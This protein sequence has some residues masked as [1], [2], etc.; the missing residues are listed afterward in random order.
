MA[1]DALARRRVERERP[2]AAAGE[3]RRRRRWPSFAVLALVVTAL[4]LWLAAR[5]VERDGVRFFHTGKQL[6]DALGGL[7]AA[8]EAGDL[9]AVEGFYDPA[10][11]AAPLGLMQRQV[12]GERDGVVV[13]R[14]APAA[15][16]GDRAAAVAEWRDYLQGFDAVDAV[17]LHVHRLEDWT[18]GEEVLAS[19][20]FEAIGTP[21]GAPRPAIDRAMLRLRFAR[22]AAGP[23]IRHAALIEGRRIASREPHFADVAAAAGIDFENRYYPA[24]LEVPLRFVMLRYG[25]AGIAAV[26]YDNDG[27]YD[28]FI[29]DGVESRLFRNRRDG[30]FEDVTEGA[31]L[32]GLSGV[33]VAVFADYDNDGFKDA[34]VSRTFEPNQLFH[35]RGDGTFEDVTAAAGI[36]EDCCTTVASWADYDNDGDLDLYVGRYLEPRTEIPTTFYARNGLPNQLYRND[37]DGSFTNVT[38]EAGVGEIGLCLGS[39]F[40]DYDDDGDLDLYV[41]NDFGRNTLYRNRGDGTFADVTVETNTLAYGAGM[42]ASFGDYDNDGRLDIYVTNIRSEFAWFGE[43]PTARRYLLNSIRQGVWLSDMPLYFE[44]FRQSGPEFHK[45]FQQMGS[46]NT[47]LR[48]LGPGADGVVRFEDVTWDARANPPG[49]FWGAS[50]ADFDNDGWQDLYAANGWVYNTPDT[51]IE[52]DFFEG[53]VADQK[54]YKTGYF[55][56]PAGFGELSWHGYERNRHLRN[57]GPGPDGRVRFTEI[58]L[59][60]GT[61]LLRNS[62]G[63]AVADFWNRGVLDLAVAASTDRHALLENRVGGRRNYLALE[64]VGAAGTLAGGSNRDAVGARVVIRAGGR[65]QLREVVLGDGYGSQNSLRLYFGLGDVERLDALEVRWPRSGRVQRFTDVAANRILELREGHDR[66]LEKTYPPALPAPP[67][68]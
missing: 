66:L 31:G 5:Y 46:G 53:V 34:F 8:L 14:F 56:D 7:A 2:A 40:G 30:T 23:K 51:E 54:K 13:E 16:A 27:F 19:V 41:V 60:A 59:A 50:F 24:F 32:S 52:L 61:A 55:Y 26:D 10:F 67:A 36:G 15:T 43:R 39:V 18:P 63:V 65:Q 47:L 62:R 38:A 11:A 42:N 3:G 17:E 29:P 1:R 68:G 28:L 4:A 49:W 58:G 48:N 44:I 33:S 20:R 35:N 6:V 22:T 37:G 45:V 21:R 12:E 57:D 9:A 25:P 64:L